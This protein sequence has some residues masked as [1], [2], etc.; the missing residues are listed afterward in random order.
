VRSSVL[1]CRNRP[2]GKKSFRRKLPFVIL[3]LLRPS[4]TEFK[5][6]A[7]PIKGPLTIYSL[8]IKNQHV[9]IAKLGFLSIGY[10]TSLGKIFRST[11]VNLRLHKNIT[12]FEHPP[13]FKPFLRNFQRIKEVG[14]VR[15]FCNKGKQRD[16][17]IG[18]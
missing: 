18:G 17:L 3:Q 16:Q 8:K 5:T 7:A 1:T 10:R 12:N 11:F 9:K 14:S 2:L 4:F 6:T 13:L 15:N